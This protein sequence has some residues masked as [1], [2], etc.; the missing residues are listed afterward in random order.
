MERFK[1]DLAGAAAEAKRIFNDVTEVQLASDAVWPW[2]VSASFHAL[3]RD[4]RLR[5]VPREQWDAFLKWK[6]QNGG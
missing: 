1:L 3:L 5:V 2:V 4:N 6:R